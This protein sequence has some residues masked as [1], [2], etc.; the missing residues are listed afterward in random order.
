MLWSKCFTNAH[1][2][3]LLFGSSA[4]LSSIVQMLCKV[5]LT[6]SRR[7]T[8]SEKGGKYCCTLAYYPFPQLPQLGF[9]LKEKHCRTLANTCL[10]PELPRLAANSSL[11]TWLPLLVIDLVTVTI[12]IVIMIINM[13]I[14]VF[15]NHF[16]HQLI[17][18]QRKIATS[19]FPFCSSWS[20][21]LP[22]WLPTWSSTWSLWSS[23]W[24]SLKIIR[25]HHCSF[26]EK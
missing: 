17:Q 18:I 9:K 2:V 16:Y 26:N 20:P 5:Q 25:Q 14:F 10:L 11:Y 23:T 21:T 4:L 6:S 22:A 12:N 8:E 1:Y 3:L 13:V 19:D 15:R 7:S 24:P